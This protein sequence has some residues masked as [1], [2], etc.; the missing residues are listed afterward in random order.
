MLNHLVLGRGRPILVLHGGRLDHR[1]MVETLEPIFQS[2]DGWRRVYVDLPGHGCSPPEANIRSLDDVLAAVMAF[3]ETVLGERCAII[4]E[5]RGGYLARGFAQ[6]RP[7]RVSG[8]ALIVPA[9]DWAADPSR[10]PAHLVAEP[11]PSLRSEVA[12]DEVWHFDN[13]M[14]VQNRAILE[15]TRRCKVPALELC[16]AEQDARVAREFELAHD[17]QGQAPVFEGPSLIVAGRQDSTTGYLDAIDLLPQF[18]RATFAV[19][20]SAGHGL[21]WERPELFDALL[22]DWLVRLARVAG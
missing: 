11:E 10:L 6:L 5:S 15:K 9:R 21:A 20:D 7:A 8:V 22:H 2:L 12:N 18:P 4:G 13:F 3:V 14:V 17:L 19:L 1:H 16:D